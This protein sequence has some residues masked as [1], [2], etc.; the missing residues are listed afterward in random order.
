MLLIYCCSVAKSCLTL[1]DPMDCS[2]PGSS[3]LQKGRCLCPPAS[4]RVCSDSSPLSQWCYLTISSSAASFSHCPQSFPASFP[5]SQLFTS[6]GQT[7]ASASVLPMNIQGWFPLGLTALISLHKIYLGLYREFCWRKRWI[8][9][10]TMPLCTPS[11]TVAE[12]PVQEHCRYSW[13]LE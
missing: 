1:W 4:P 3:V 7:S 9:R 11:I 2:T 8:E 10:I 6:R 13:V 5:M 12:T